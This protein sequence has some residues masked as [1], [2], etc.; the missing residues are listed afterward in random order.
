MKKKLT[1]MFVALITV[2]AFAIQSKR[3]AG[4]EVKYALSEGDTFTSGQIVEVK[5]GTDVVATI[6]Y[7]ETGGNAFSAAV[8]AEGGSSLDGYTA[9]T[10]GNGTNGNKPGGT[11]YTIKPVYNGTIN[12]AVILNAEKAFYI[13]E[14]GEALAGYNGITVDA[15]YYG[16]YKFDVKAGKSYKV[17]C[18]GSKLSFYGF[19]YVYEEPSAVTYAVNV[20]DGIT[21]G[22]VKV[23]KATAAEGEEVTITTTPADGYMLDAISVTCK[24][25]DEAVTV[26][27]GKFTMPADDVTVNA[28]FKV[29]PVDVTVEASDIT[30]GDITAAIAAKA[31]GKPIGNITINLAENGAYTVS[32]PIEAGAG[33]KIVGA[34]GAKIDASA[35]T[36][37]F[38]L[39][40]KTP[41]VAGTTV[42]TNEVY[43]VAEVS[44]KDVE[45]TGLPYQLF[46]ANGVRYLVGK[47]SVDN[48]VIGINGTNKKTIFD[49][50]GRGCAEEISVN[51]STIWANPSNA[52]NGGLYSSQSGDWAGDLGGTKQ[53][54]SITNSTIYNIANGKTICTQ[55]QNSK[56]GMGFV[57]KNSIILDSGKSGQFVVGLDGG[58]Y[59]SAP[60]WDIDKN[61]FNFGGADV[62]A[63]ES[64]KVVEGGG[65]ADIIKNSIAGVV[66]FAN[67]DYATT[68]NF[69]LANCAQNT[70]HIGDPRWLDATVEPEPEDIVISPASGDII[71]ALFEATTGA[72]KKAKNITINLAENG[73]YTI[74]KSIEAGAGV[75]IVG[76]AG[77]KIDASALTTPFILMSKTPA[78]AGTTVGTNEVYNVAEV[79][80]K[81][82][83]I[84][85]LPYQLF[86]ANG[87][88]YLV[89]K[90]SVDN[91]V[92]GINGTNKKTIF[93]FAGRGCAEEI[94]VNNS[95]IWANPSNAQNGGLYSS[96]SGD[97]AGDLGGTKQILSITNSTIYNIANGKTICT[98]RQNSKP[99]MGFVVK[100]SIILDSGKSG[101]FVVGLDGGSYKSAPTWDIDKNAFNFGGADVSAAES[102]K[103]VEGGGTADIIKNSIAGVVAFA[104]TDY[105]TTGNFTL[106][107]SSLQNMLQIGDPR[108]LVDFAASQNVT[109]AASGY[110]T[111]VS[112]YPLDFTTA[113]G[114]TAYVVA[115]DED[116]DI[117]NS[118]VKLTQVTEAAANTPVILKGTASTEYTI[119]AKADAAAVT[120]NLLKGSATAATTLTAGEAYLLKDGKF[121]LCA[122]GELPAGKAYLPVPAGSA[123]NELIIV[124][125]GEVTGIDKVVTRDALENA[126]IYNLQGQEVKKA[127]KGIYII[128]GKKVVMK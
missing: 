60:T 119:T 96:Q 102:A 67:T 72:N 63:A 47:L 62:S 73:A 111:L 56:P 58:S 30:G 93:D 8:A 59:K 75:K 68:G 83:E 77:A 84:T 38:I 69:K 44:V 19:T 29:A 21:N 128:N 10:A 101:Q 23:D 50:A 34:A 22:T 107:A 74:S 14:D 53:I 27:D 117:T 80:V 41:A 18:S 115:A 9:Y 45:I 20:A 4:D 114:L 76:A 43:N 13:E 86:F 3:A 12:I 81:D 113:A 55:R 1:F 2:A 24:N 6:T 106:G 37:P 71:A 124:I 39:M 48:S 95:T 36:T 105:A 89:G 26:K 104:N 33:V 120:G 90:L 94:S 99:G 31:A 57:V 17:Y 42:G 123:S 116:I 85:G 25:K 64:A 100:N 109:T 79:S 16:T 7:G 78:V 61:A 112:V 66:A 88:R 49:F 46:F 103:V 15:K 92:I 40:S 54:L 91:S 51:N 126:K 121:G 65:T 108:W 125:D 98:Q 82:V 87:V 32:A 118:K 70:A 97:W 127:G 28:T 35:L 5:D 52:Q 122:A 110:T 11:F